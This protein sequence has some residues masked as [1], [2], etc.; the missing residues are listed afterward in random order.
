MVLG[1]AENVRAPA[2]N[3]GRHAAIMHLFGVAQAGIYALKSELAS[4][5][6]FAKTCAESPIIFPN[7]RTRMSANLASR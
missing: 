1:I 6:S 7:R 2:G 4:I 3:T 5:L